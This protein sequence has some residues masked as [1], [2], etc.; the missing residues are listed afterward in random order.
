MPSL[1]SLNV[2]IPIEDVISG[3]TIRLTDTEGRMP[4]VHEI[5]P[6]KIDESHW[7]LSCRTSRR[8]NPIPDE[9]H[10][11]RH[12]WT[13]YPTQLHDHGGVHGCIVTLLRCLVEQRA[14]PDARH[15]E[16]LVVGIR[17]EVSH[18]RRYVARAVAR[19]GGLVAETWEGAADASLPLY[20]PS[21]E[22][23][24]HRLPIAPDVDPERLLLRMVALWVDSVP[25]PVPD[26]LVRRTLAV[27]DCEHE[28]IGRAEGAA[29]HLYHEVRRTYTHAR[30][31]MAE[32]YPWPE[33]WSPRELVH[34]WPN[35]DVS[36][37][38]AVEMYARFLH[39][40]PHPGDDTATPSNVRS[41]TL[42]VNA[43]RIE[44]GRYQLV[45]VKY[46]APVHDV[47]M[48]TAVVQYTQ[49]PPTHWDAQEVIR[50]GSLL[51]QMNPRNP[52]YRR[53]RREANTFMVQS[54]ARSQ[55][56]IRGLLQPLPPTPEPEGVG[57]EVSYVEIDG[58]RVPQYTRTG[59]WPVLQDA[60]PPDLDHRPG[61][62]VFNSGKAQPRPRRSVRTVRRVKLEP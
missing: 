15:G 24:W 33:Q 40:G 44:S 17:Q 52:L 51:D 46:R 25:A 4:Y 62:H 49:P 53:I 2:S 6:L 23:D 48:R 41:L 45:H 18:G 14:L 20:Q 28:L 39:G 37:Y 9:L 19:I 30:D 5:N 27:G 32:R 38:E 16:P 22:D 35:G 55:V 21:T 54:A 34:V 11:W 61:W 10:P 29:T 58:Q 13:L 31:V 1:E 26:P 42:Y 47:V 56:A 59:R 7:R 8:H 57:H 3:H 12:A 36:P 50:T 43:A 60:I